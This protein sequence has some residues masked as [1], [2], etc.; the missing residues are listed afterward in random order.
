MPGLIGRNSHQIFTVFLGHFREVVNSTVTDAPIS[1]VTKGE[2]AKISFGKSEA[3]LAV[4]LRTKPWFLYLGQL[5]AAVPEGGG[6]WRLRTLKYS[7]RIQAGPSFNDPWYFRFEYVSREIQRSVHPRHHL[8]IPLV[9]ACGP[10][11]VDLAKTHLP[12]G[13]LTIEELIRFLI[14]GC[15]VRP[16]RKE[17]D[18]FLQESEE[19]FRQWTARS[20]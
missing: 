15:G 6:V 10:R 2:I 19:R 5:L 12:T 20:V 8:H 9:L 3:P 17:W 7:Y 11:S 1:L 18:R 14:V 4:P 16:K 13:W